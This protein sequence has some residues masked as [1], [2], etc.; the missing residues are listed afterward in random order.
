MLLIKNI[1][2]KVVSMYSVSITRRGGKGGLYQKLILTC[3]CCDI[4]G[5][6]KPYQQGG[7]DGVL[8]QQQLV[9]LPCRYNHRLAMLQ[10]HSIQFYFSKGTKSTC[11]SARPRCVEVL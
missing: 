10:F 8:Y 9:P 11:P 2:K 1:N 3:I 5:Q 6:F 4:R 7:L